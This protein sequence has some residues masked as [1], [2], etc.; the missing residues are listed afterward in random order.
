M[1]LELL[2]LNDG[3]RELPESSGDAVHNLVLLHDVLHHLASPAH[4]LL[5]F[6]RQ[7]FKSELSVIW[8]LTNLN[9]LLVS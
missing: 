7:L 1:L 3:P 6:F 9:Q 8:A 5:R 2:L 4:L